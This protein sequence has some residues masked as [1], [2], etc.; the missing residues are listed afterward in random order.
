MLRYT[1]R[2]L[3]WLTVAVAIACGWWLSEAR[4]RATQRAA[5]SELMV[6]QIKLLKESW[7]KEEERDRAD[8][9]ALQADALNEL[10]QTNGTKE[11]VKEEMLGTNGS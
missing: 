6:L 1:T 4:N 3:L 10:L 5:K 2:D 11:Q 7:R 8:Q 9:Q